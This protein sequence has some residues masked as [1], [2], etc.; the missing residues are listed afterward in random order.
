MF[1][2]TYLAQ[3]ACF[4]KIFSFYPLH[5]YFYS[6]LIGMGDMRLCRWGDTLIL[7][8]ACVLSRRDVAI[9][10]RGKTT[11]VISRLF[12]LIWSFYSLRPSKWPTLQSSLLKPWIVF[13][14]PVILLLFMTG[15]LN[16]WKCNLQRNKKFLFRYNRIKSQFQTLF[17]AEPQFY[18]RAPGRVNLIGN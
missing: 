3:K 15:I 11:E 12:T 14:L 13:S 1:I 8:E 5:V 18:A 10:K 7:Y 6:R 16:R 17:G 4:G 9:N 2:A